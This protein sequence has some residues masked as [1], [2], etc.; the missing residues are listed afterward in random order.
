MSDDDIDAVLAITSSII[1]S[2]VG[3]ED[4]PSLYILVPFNDPDFGPLLKTT[5]PNVFKNAIDSLR[6]EGGGDS[7]EMSLSGLQ[8]ALTGAPP[9]SEIF[10]FT[11][12]PAK[13]THLK[14]TVITLIERTK[15]VVNFM[16]TAA[17]RSRRR[18]RAAAEDLAQVSGGLAIEVTMAEL[19]AATS[20]ITQSSTSSLV[21]LLQANRNPGKADNFTFSV[22]ESVRKITVYIAGTSTTFSLTNPSG[23]SQES[24][25]NRGPLITASQSVGNFKTL[26]LKAETGL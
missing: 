13:D 17:L 11:D 16:I 3:T 10:L 19:P 21:S 24:R 4:E 26:Q 7:P 20:I 2:K 15:S 8:L 1:D 9:E 6:A 5:D 14:S 12:A 23:V 22:D 18:K 25:N